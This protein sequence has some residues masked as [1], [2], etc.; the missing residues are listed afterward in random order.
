MLVCLDECKINKTTFD[1]EISELKEDLA[2]KEG[3]ELLNERLVRL[4]AKV[5]DLDKSGEIDSLSNR[6][7]ALVDT[8]IG[9]LAK[10]DTDF[11][12]QNTAVTSSQL[13]VDYKDET[14]GSG[15]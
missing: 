8:F 14:R 9:L 12:A 1:H 10:M 11:T 3:S 13:D 2:K 5:N 6:I 4:E 15:L 7:E